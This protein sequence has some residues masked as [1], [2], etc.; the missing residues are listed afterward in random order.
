M[1]H[2]LATIK[3][4][5]GHRDDFLVEL[6]KVVPLVRA[7]Q[8]CLDYTP[9]VDAETTLPAQEPQRSDVVVIVE[10]WESLPALEAHLVAPHMMEYRPKV[11]D[12]IANVSLQILEPVSIG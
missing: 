6:K 8:G 10:K 11:R 9:A 3:L 12:M 7:E 4:H 5:P 2:V 1:I